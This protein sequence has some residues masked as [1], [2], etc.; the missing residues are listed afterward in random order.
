MKSTSGQAGWSAV[1]NPE[2]ARDAVTAWQSGDVLDVR[3][4][5]LERDFAVVNKGARGVNAI[6]RALRVATINAVNGR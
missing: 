5:T 6:N 2:K 3:T 1:A 4:L